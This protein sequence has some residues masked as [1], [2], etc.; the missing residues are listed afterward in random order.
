MY[1]AHITAVTASGPSAIY[2]ITFNYI[3]MRNITY[4]K[5]EMEKLFCSVVVHVFKWCHSAL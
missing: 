4:M 2:R 3:Q 1:V 5:M